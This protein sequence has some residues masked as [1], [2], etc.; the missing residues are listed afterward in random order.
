MK[1]HKHIAQA[2]ACHKTGSGGALRA[3]SDTIPR[4]RRHREPEMVMRVAR[5]INPSV[6]PAQIESDARTKSR[7]DE[8]SLGSAD[9]ARRHIAHVFISP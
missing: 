2:H 4:A 8:S 1:G 3:L 9:P 6:H 5:P 7:R